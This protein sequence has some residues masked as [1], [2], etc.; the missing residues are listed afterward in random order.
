MKFRMSVVLVAGIVLGWALWALSNVE[1]EFTDAR[2]AATLV[3]AGDQGS[4]RAAIKAGL[5][6]Y[7]GTL[8]I[9]VS[10][11]TD[12]PLQLVLIRLSGDRS[13]RLLM[14]RGG[15]DSNRE[16]VVCDQLGELFKVR[17][18]EEM[19]H[20]FA[21]VDG[22]SVVLSSV[23]WT[24]QALGA[25]AQAVIEIDSEAV[26]GSYQQQFDSLWAS[27]S[28]SCSDRLDLP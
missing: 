27:G 15:V 16:T 13:I 20:R 12:Q 7:S 17:F 10:D 19:G 3:D 25:A 23:D 9:A 8:D 28:S 5:E 22:K 1:L 26:A 24:F 4:A 18:V 11:F 14:G 21:I 2:V 6:R